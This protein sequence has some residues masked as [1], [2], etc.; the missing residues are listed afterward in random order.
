MEGK[1]YEK[2]SEIKVNRDTGI[3]EVSLTFATAALP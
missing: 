1:V 2:L 3:K